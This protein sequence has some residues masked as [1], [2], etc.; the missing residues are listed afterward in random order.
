MMTMAWRWS[1]RQKMF[2]RVRGWR[3]V[4]RWKAEKRDIIMEKREC[5]WI[6]RQQLQQLPSPPHHHTHH[7]HRHVLSLLFLKQLDHH[8]LHLFF[9]Y[10]SVHIFIALFFII[11]YRLRRRIG[12]L[13]CCLPASGNLSFFLPK[14]R[15]Q[16]G[17]F[18]KEDLDI[19][20]ISMGTEAG[21]RSLLL[22]VQQGS[23]EASGDP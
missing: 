4:E 8:A 16:T 17:S 10:L 11:I 21:R 18:F 9:E 20:S 5:H 7:Q 13:S 22:N 15:K 14:N 2:E 23:E 6:P 19:N 1:K 3:D 12:F